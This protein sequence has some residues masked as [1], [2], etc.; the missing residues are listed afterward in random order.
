MNGAINDSHTLDEIG[1]LE[2]MSPYERDAVLLVYVFNDIDYLTPVTDRSGWM[3]P[4]GIV[5]R[6]HPARLAF[7][8]SYLFQELFVHARMARYA[9]SDQPLPSQRAYADGDLLDRHLDDIERFVRIASR[10]EVPVWI[11]P[12]SFWAADLE[13]HARLL[14]GLPARAGFRC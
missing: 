9:A 6:M 7:L 13:S 12:F 14:E 8:N 5:H 4:G 11:V 10:G 1:Y 3:Q 2:R